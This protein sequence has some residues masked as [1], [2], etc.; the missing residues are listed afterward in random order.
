VALMFKGVFIDTETGGLDPALVGVNQIGLQAFTAGEG[1]VWLHKP[2]NLPIWPPEFLYYCDAALKVQNR[3]FVEVMD[4]RD[5]MTETVALLR[6]YEYIAEH[7]EDAGPKNINWAG[8]IWAHNAPFDWAI[9]KAMQGRCPQASLKII[10][11]H[12]P[13]WSCTKAKWT[14]M[15]GRGMVDSKASKLTEIAAYLNLND[16]QANFHDAIY[17]CVMGAHVLEA[18]MQIEREYYRR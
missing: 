10:E 16:D 11:S 2:L 5:A 4:A 15:S 9:I 1:S 8:R 3:T 12:R 18:M 14:E 6:A 7:L 17:D 13:D